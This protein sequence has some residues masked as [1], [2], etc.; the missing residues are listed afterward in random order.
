MIL[1][2]VF[3]D[4][5]MLF[6]DFEMFVYDFEKLFNDFE[7]SFYNDLSSSSNNFESWKTYKGG[8]GRFSAPPPLVSVFQRTKIVQTGA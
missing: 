7:L 1:K 6:N 2:C 5:E 3:N 8:A 4:S